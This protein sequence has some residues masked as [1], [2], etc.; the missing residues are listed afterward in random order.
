MNKHWECVTPDGVTH[1][2]SDDCD[3]DK[4]CDIMGVDPEVTCLRCLGGV[5]E[6]LAQD[7]EEARHHLAMLNPEAWQCMPNCD[8]CPITEF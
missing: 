8:Y 6:M 7:L 1:I 2:G 5:I 4:A 3:T